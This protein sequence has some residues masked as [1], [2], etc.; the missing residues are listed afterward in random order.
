[1]SRAF[2][3]RPSRICYHL[4]FRYEDR[5]ALGRLASLPIGQEATAI[6]EV[7][8]VRESRAGRRG[9]PVLEVV[10]RDGDGQL[11]LVWFHGIAWFRRRFREG[12]RLLVHGR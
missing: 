1:S 5:R 9:R 7:W 4:P 3:S 2:A 10:V 11:A 12:Q 6:G 8:R